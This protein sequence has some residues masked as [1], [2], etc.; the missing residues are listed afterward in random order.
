MIAGCLVADFFHSCPQSSHQ[1]PFGA[2][3]A[4]NLLPFPH[5]L[6]R[7]VRPARAAKQHRVHLHRRAPAVPRVEVKEEW[8]EWA[9]LRHWDVKR[10][11]IA[12]RAPW[13]AFATSMQALVSNVLAIR[14]A[15]AEISASIKFVLLAVRPINLVKMVCRAAIAFVMM[16]RRITTIAADVISHVARW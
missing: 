11:R 3:T 7:P 12:H 6:L 5:R 14:N 1:L 2:V 13:E 16:F 4:P 15:Q 8:E 9:V 10:I